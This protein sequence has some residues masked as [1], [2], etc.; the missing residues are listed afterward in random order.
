MRLEWRPARWDDWVA[1]VGLYAV[2]LVVLEGAVYF[3][4]PTRWVPR[5]F[6]KRLSDLPCP[7]CGAYRAFRA[8]LQ[9]DIRGALAIQPLLTLLALTAAAL[10]GYALLTACGRLPRFHLVC[11][12]RERRAVWLAA[13][14]LVLLN[15][16]YLIIDGR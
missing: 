6:F 5:C 4:L 12:P 11:S 15:W 13:G 8:L 7:T 3:F 16:L 14:A 1:M 9:G 10:F 2:P